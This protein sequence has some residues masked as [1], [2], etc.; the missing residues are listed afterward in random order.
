MTVSPAFAAL[1][2]AEF[3]ADLNLWM[4]NRFGATEPQIMRVGS[5][6]FI[7]PSLLGILKAEIHEKFSKMSNELIMGSLG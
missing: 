3:V 7:A 4:L 1:M 5:A 2:P 6:I